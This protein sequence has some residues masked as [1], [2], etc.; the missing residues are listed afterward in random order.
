MYCSNKR[1]LA[2]G[3]LVAAIGVSSLTPAFSQS[4]ASPPTGDPAKASPTSTQPEA[5]TTT[6]AQERKSKTAAHKAKRA[7]KNAELGKLEKNGYNPANDDA[8]YPGNIQKA[9]KKANAGSKWSW[10]GLWL[11][12]AGGPPQSR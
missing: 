8:D 1:T 2:S 3:F 9:E 6:P 10:N 7:R 12:R 5:S 4:T 11:P